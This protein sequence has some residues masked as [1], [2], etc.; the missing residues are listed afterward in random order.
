MG[1][2]LLARA[3]PTSQTGSLTLAVVQQYLPDATSITESGSPPV[4]DVRNADGQSIA[5]ACLTSPQA[6]KIVGYAGPNNVL[7]IL[8]TDGSVQQMHWLQWLDT[9]DHVERVRAADE[10]W[11][12]FYGRSLGQSDSSSATQVDGVSGA[13]LTSLAIAEAIELRLSGKRPSLRFPQA[14]TLDEVQG[15]YPDAQ[16]MTD[17]PQRTGFW[18]AL[19]ASGRA[20]GWLMRTGPLVDDKIGYQGPTELWLAIDKDERVTK[21]KLRSSYDNEPYVRYTRMEASFWSKFVGRTLTELS[22][23]D[24]AAEGIEGV[25]GATMT[26]MAAADT[27]RAVAERHLQQ[28]VDSSNPQPP[29][30]KWNWSLGELATGVLACLLVPWSLSKLR[31]QRRSRMLWQVFAF[32]VIVGL[33]GNLISMALLAGWTRSGP[34]L[35]FAPG[36][37]L[38]VLVSLAMPAFIGRNVYCDHVCP[39]GMVQ[40]WLMR[41]QGRKPTE[42]VPLVQLQL[43]PTGQPRKPTRRGLH[44]VLKLSS[45]I[46]LMLCVGWVVWTVPSQ[47]TFFEPFDVYAWRIGW[48]VS[49][50][51]WLGSLLLAAR[52]PMGYCRL[53][54]PTGMLLEG[55]R[56]KRAGRRWQS[57]DMLLI[58]LTALVWLLLWRMAR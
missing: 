42:A 17:D 27:V 20:L 54:C 41:W 29:M 23:I 25:S 47:L 28:Q 12:Q 44:R 56:R 9:H 37:A 49:L 21:I 14:V 51:V 38:L 55:I 26:S 34:P 46:I 36:L 43:Q 48:S 24:Y 50:V 2:H 5:L 8:N 10:F 45:L 39:H 57:S 11:Q 22:T 33:S 58:A 15:I 7:L 6:D 30:R 13:T 1:L 3:R 35:A 4:W 53:A 32:V 16:S 18:C 40:Q 19:D 52:E 31:G